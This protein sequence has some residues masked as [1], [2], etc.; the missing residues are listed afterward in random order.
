MLLGLFLATTVCSPWSSWEKKSALQFISKNT[1]VSL[2]PKDD[3]VSSMI[4]QT[5][6]HLLWSLAEH[7]KGRLSISIL[8]VFMYRLAKVGVW[9]EWIHSVLITLLLQENNHFYLKII[10]VWINHV[11]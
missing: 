11:H 7:C 4:L 9:G 6:R 3:H 2:K 5:L 10:F 1:E 8:Y